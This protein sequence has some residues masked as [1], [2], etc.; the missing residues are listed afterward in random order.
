MNTRT[1]KQII[2][3]IT[4]VVAAAA[5]V[6]AG[7]PDSGGTNDLSIGERVWPPIS[8]G[9]L[10]VD[11]RYIPPPYVVSRKEGD[12]FVNEHGI[13]WVFQW[14][15]KKTSAPPPPPEHEPLMPTCITETTT[16]FDPEYIN[17]VSSCR[18]Y[19]FS[20]FGED[21]GIDEMVGVY[22]K[23]PCILD[24][25]RASNDNKT[26]IIVKWKTG[27]TSRIRLV[28]PHRKDIDLTKEQAENHIDKTAELFVRGLMRNKYYIVEG[29][30]PSRSGNP[31][32]AKQTFLPLAE[33]MRT[34]KDEAE[35]LAIMVTNQPPGGMS[36]KMLRSF[37]K[38]KDEVP[39]WEPR[40]R[41]AAEKGTR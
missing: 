13:A 41:E 6:R 3:I 35:Y 8:N 19:F 11:G 31:E 14:P 1:V 9:V 27:E 34:A 28:P 36:E 39:K 24:A 18:H 5:T 30:S 7:V 15:P 22:N 10:F 26:T 17:F 32:G 21:K 20:K 12:V 4:W 37:Y 40:V 38:Y 23:L 29:R 25:K 16:K 33:A 2:G